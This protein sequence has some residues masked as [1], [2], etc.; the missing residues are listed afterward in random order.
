M[1][2]LG[3]APTGG[4]TEGMMTMAQITTA[5]FA[6]ELNTDTRTVR[7]FLR[8]ITPKDEQPGKGSRWVLEGTKRELAKSRKQFAEWTA[9]TEA[10]KAEKA[11]APD[12]DEAAE[13]ELDEEP[14]DEAIE[15]EDAIDDEDLELDD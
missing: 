9:A 5:E 10:R 6:A 2:V 15:A 12:T 11:P 8:S 14:T 1:V 3:I 4:L 7:K 13:V